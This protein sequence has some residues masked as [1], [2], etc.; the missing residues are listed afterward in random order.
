MRTGWRIYCGIILLLFYA[1]SA[2]AQLSQRSEAGVGIGTLNY[3]G[4]LVRFYNFRFSSPAATVFYRNNVNPVV[5]F[6]ASLTGGRLRASDAAHPIDPFAAARNASFNIFVME[7]S[8]C[9]EYHFLDWRDTKR[10]LRFTPYVVSGLALFTMSG[11]P[12]KNAAYSNVQ[13]AVP[14]GVGIKYVINPK[15][16]AAAE[17]GAR[18]SGFDYLDNI[19]DG[20]PAFKNLQY[21]NK[22]DADIYYFLG[23]TITRTFYDIP[24]PQSPY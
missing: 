4:D 16:Y 20:N 6:R 24:C 11:I 1:A 22:F 9:F 13:L 10:R 18:F 12:N 19:S 14:L 8:A 3:T 21:G 2:D 15:W 7:A 23:V 17:F 5:S